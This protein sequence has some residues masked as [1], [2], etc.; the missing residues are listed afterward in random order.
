M[1]PL[2]RSYGPSLPPPVP[3]SIRGG[4]V[5]SA[6][7][8]VL[9]SAVTLECEARGVPQPAVTW[10]RG[11]QVLLSSRQAQYGERGRF[12]E[13]P[14]AQARDAGSYACRVTSVAGAAEKSY[15]LD[16]YREATP[17]DLC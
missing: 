6:V 15:E 9:D 5:T 7:V 13:I 16:V 1:A 11:G 14:R 2:H 17:P 10:Y 12:L 8:A 4:N 3:P